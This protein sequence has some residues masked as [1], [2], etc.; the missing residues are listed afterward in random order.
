[1]NFTHQNFKVPEKSS[2]W[3]HLGQVPTLASQQGLEEDLQRDG[4]SHWS[5]KVQSRET[6]SPDEVGARVLFREKETLV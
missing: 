3:P 4:S 2:D 6:T 5:P 1:M